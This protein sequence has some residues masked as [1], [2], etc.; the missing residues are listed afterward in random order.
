MS[1]QPAAPRQPQ[2]PCTVHTRSLSSPHPRAFLDLPHK[3]STH[4]QAKTP[5]FSPTPR[6]T[7]VFQHQMTAQQP[8]RSDIYIRHAPSVTSQEPALPSSPRPALVPASLLPR[9][10]AQPTRRRAPSGGGVTSASR[11]WARAAA[12][13]F[14]PAQSRS[15]GRLKP[16]H[17]FS[18]NSVQWGERNI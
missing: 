6:E 16:V 13:L 9:R 1:C 5:Q 8:L 15:G 14:C 12:C 3:G 18:N 17:L 4:F 2:T 11:S 7:I 10:P